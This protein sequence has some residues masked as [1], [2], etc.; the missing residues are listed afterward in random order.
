MKKTKVNI[1]IVVGLLINS[2]KYL[3][4]LPDSLACFTTA[5]GIVLL[6]FGLYLANNDM[7]KLKKWKRNIFKKLCLLLFINLLIFNFTSY[8]YADKIKPISPSGLSKS[9]LSSSIESYIEKHKHT[10]A[11][12]AISVFNDREEL[13]QGY[14][15]YSDLEK[16]VPVLEDTVFEWGSVSK[17]LTWVSVFQL[18]EKGEIDLNEDIRT[19]LPQGF[20]KKVSKNEKITMMNLM[21]HDGGWQEGVVDFFIEDI[22]D[23]KDLK[24]SLERTEPEQIYPLGQY[25]AYSNWGATLAAY[26]VQEISGQKYYQYVHENIFKPLDMNKT[27]LLPDLRDNEWVQEK[28]KEIKG[29][30]PDNKVID[31]DFY[32]IALYPS[33]MATGTLEDLEKFGKS[34]IGYKEEESLFQN[35]ETLDRL[36]SPSLYYEASKYPRNANGFWFT[37]FAVST[38]GHGGTTKAFSSNL[39]IDPI[40]KTSAIIMTNQS[41]ESI[42]NIEILPIIFGDFNP[43]QPSMSQ[44]KKDIGGIYGSARTFARG[45][46]RLHSIISRVKIKEEDDGRIKFI[47]PGFSFEGYEFEPSLYNVDGTLYQI[48]KDK[49]GSM[50]MSTLYQDFYRV[51]TSRIIIDY[52]LVILAIL[53]LLYSTISLLV[54]LLGFIRRKRKDKANFKDSLFKFHIFTLLGIVLVFVNVSILAYK[55]L[56]FDILRNV[57]PHIYLLFI[58]M[59]SLLGVSIFLIYSLRRS[60]IK[61]RKRLKYILTSIGSLIISLNIFY[62]Q[63]Y[64]IK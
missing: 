56:N 53:A 24:E 44:E 37:E 60:N 62:W 33:G 31:K 50:I 63:L 52:G 42:F 49:D 48:Y 10:T 5:M 32:H 58:L 17:L 38:L 59:I 41:Y 40:S 64:L 30:T 6:I 13:Y 3:I 55:M 22:K 18:W 7:T 4:D 51:K 1:Y 27:A 19:Y 61:G 54:D 11:G 21:H 45:Y 46:G 16:Q 26:I 34:L 39:L 29:Y 43:S 47:G 8:A 57:R 12:L 28:R 14:H 9:E 2:L 36:L 15:G 35:E 25:K 20:L 23:V